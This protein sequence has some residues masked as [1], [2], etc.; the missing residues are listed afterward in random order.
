MDRNFTNTRNAAPV[1]EDLD[2]QAHPGHGVPSQ[3]PTATAQFLLEPE[4]SER[5]ANSVLMGGG[6]V[7]GAATGAAVG[8]VV[9]GP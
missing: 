3:D 2:E 6:M 4:E 1:D 8:V 7:A 9:A 5:E